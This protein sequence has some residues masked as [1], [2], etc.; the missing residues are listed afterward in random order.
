MLKKVFWRL[1]RWLGSWAGIACNKHRTSPRLIRNYLICILVQL[2]TAYSSNGLDPF[3]QELHSG[4]YGLS[5]DTLH[6]TIISSNTT[7]L[8]P[9]LI[10]TY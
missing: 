9:C 5:Q 1:G 10:R 4:M 2:E 3:L 8:F 6:P 7:L